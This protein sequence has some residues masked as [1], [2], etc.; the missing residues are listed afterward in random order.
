ME[1]KLFDAINRFAL[2]NEFT[3]NGEAEILEQDD[4]GFVCWRISKDPLKTSLL[5]VANYN[6]PTEKLTETDSEGNTVKLIK[7][8][9]AVYDKEIKLP[10]DLKMV[11][12]YKYDEKTKDIEEI[13]FEKPLTEITF[14][15]LNPSEY[16]IYKLEQ[17]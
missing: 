8:G 5:V 4:D 2:N 10:C 7:E 17:V 6:P 13:V 12:E 11:S 9:A 3:L 16:R 15:T 14:Y 1:K